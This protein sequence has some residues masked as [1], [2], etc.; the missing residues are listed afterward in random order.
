MEVDTTNG[1][2]ADV[3]CPYGAIGDR[4]WV[5]EAFASAD[6][7]YQGH[8]NDIPSVVAYRADKSAI[9]WDSDRPRS[10]PDWDRVQWNWDAL[11]WKSRASMPRDF[12]RLFLDVVAVRVERLQAITT[13]DIAAE[14][15][16]PQPEG[17]FV[18]RRIPLDL[19]QRFRFI[20]WWDELHGKRAPWSSNP[21]VWRLEFR[22]VNP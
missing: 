9:Q 15:L 8:E 18:R 10:I 22:R 11:R 20:E 3:P 16:L 19:R 6:T 4:L 7:M 17:P 2:T 12:A 5:Q 14:G 1:C 13:E 21:W